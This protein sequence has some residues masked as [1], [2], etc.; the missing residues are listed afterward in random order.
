MLI[1]DL[2]NSAD[3][4]RNLQEQSGL[5]LYCWLSWTVKIFRVNDV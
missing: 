4:M 3:M 2:V 5:D 1:K